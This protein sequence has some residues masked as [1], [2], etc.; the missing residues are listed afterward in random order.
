MDE[1]VFYYSMQDDMKTLIAT[2]LA[3]LANDGTTYIFIT[4][5]PILFPLE[6]YSLGIP[7]LPAL[8]LIGVLVALQNVFSVVASPLVGRIA[9]KTRRYRGLLSL[10]LFL[11]GVGVVGYALSVLLVSGGLLFL[12]LIPFSIIAGIG[13]AFYHPLG[14]SMLSQTWPYRSVGKAMGINGASG[15]TGRALYPL[16]VVSLVAY[17]TTPGVIVLAF[18]G[19]AIA[20]VIYFILRKVNFALT[21]QASSIDKLTKKEN[22]SKLRKTT[23]P[24]RT[25]IRSILVLTIVAF[26]RGVFALGVVSFIPE[27]LERVSGVKYGVELGLVF[28]LILTL[29]VLGQLAFGTLAD[30]LGRR[31]AL[32]ISTIGSSVAILLLLETNN[33]YLQLSLLALFGFFVFTQFPLLMPLSSNAVPKEAV[34]LSNSIVWGI[35]NS[36]GNSL[37]PFLVGLLA[38]PFFLGSL[39]GAFFVVAIISLVSAPML[40]FVPE[41]QKGR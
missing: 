16:L 33:I 25:I 5:Y 20:L 23:I 30:N 10:G 8:F 39:N 11:M 21:Q 28:S 3:H 15:S 41:V 24:L 6:Y 31:L 32:G 36:G 1:G 37:G 29:P 2:S 14:G 13:G 4:L 40:T 19:F 35:G 17:L 34:T 12:I 27:Y 18:L 7:K 22:E 26:L 9:D 38:T